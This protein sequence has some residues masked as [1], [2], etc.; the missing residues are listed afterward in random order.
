MISF[1]STAIHNFKWVK[2]KITYFSAVR[3]NLE[4]KVAHTCGDSGGFGY[5]T[6][7]D[8]E[9]ENKKC[10]VNVNRHIGRDSATKKLMVNY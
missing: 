10:D 9:Q 4:D 3:V 7:A 1:H 6:G 5:G 2:I 8:A